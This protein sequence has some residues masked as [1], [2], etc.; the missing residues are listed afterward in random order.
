[1]KAFTALAATAITV[2]SLG[3][4][5]MAVADDDRCSASKSQWR[6]LDDVR[7]AATS[8]GYDVRKIDTDDG[9]Y[10]VYARDDRGRR[11][12]VYFHPVSLDV[13]KIKEDD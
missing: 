8:L 12:E 4:A 10:E 7:S 11:L 13:V 1:M 3:T 2:A 5:G 6:S 9:C